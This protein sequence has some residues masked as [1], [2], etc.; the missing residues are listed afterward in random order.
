MLLSRL[1]ELTSAEDQSASILRTTADN[2]LVAAVEAE[3]AS[4]EVVEEAVV[5]VAS[6]AAT[7][8]AAVA[9]VASEVAIEAVVEAEEVV[10][11]CTRSPVASLISPARK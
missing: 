11:H 9:E 5:V 4:E 1:Q 3:A 7:E 6:E 2:R 8:A 10:V